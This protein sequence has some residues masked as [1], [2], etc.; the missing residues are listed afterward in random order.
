[1]RVRRPGA[2]VI[3]GPVLV[4]EALAA[5]VALD[6]GVRRR[7]RRPTPSPAALHEAVTAASAAGVARRGSA[8][9]C[10]PGSPTPSPPS[11]VAAV[12]GARR[13]RRSTTLRSPSAPAGSWCSCSPASADPGNAGTLLRSAEAAGAAGVVFA[14]GSVDLF[15][16]KIVRAVGRLAV[17]RARSSRPTTSADAA[18]RACGPPGSPLVGTV[19]ARRRALR[20]GRPHRRRSR[21]C[22]RQRGPRPRPPTLA[23]GSTRTRHHPDGRR[24]SRASTSPWPAPCSLFEAARQRRSAPPSRRLTARSAWS[25]GLDD[26]TSDGRLTPR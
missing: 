8:P 7:R 1:M 4:A 6:G 26:P 5:G 3:E 10:W 2:F 18:R 19:A 15:G 13:R 11:G 14:G 17:P 24:G 25:G 20:R 12:V 9:A 22:C 16:P 23:A 21:S